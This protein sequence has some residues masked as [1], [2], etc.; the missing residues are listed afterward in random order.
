MMATLAALIGAWGTWLLAVWFVAG[1]PD[2]KRVNLLLTLPGMLLFIA[3]V[4]GVVCL[5]LGPLARRLRL[6]AV[7]SQISIFA[8]LV[9]IAPLVTL[10]IFA[11][12]NLR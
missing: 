5:I 6:Q 2:A 12:A 4:T 3:I 1:D 9:G 8:F 11:L 7:P 10:V